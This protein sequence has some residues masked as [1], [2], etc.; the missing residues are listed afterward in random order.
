M[1][2]DV[3]MIMLALNIMDYWEFKC[4]VLNDY[5]L[6]VKLLPINFTYIT[7]VCILKQQFSISLMDFLQ[8]SI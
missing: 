4:T 5:F 2:Y 7:I 6:K 3:Y 8:I 1:S